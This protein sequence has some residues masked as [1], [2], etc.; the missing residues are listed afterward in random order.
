MFGGIGLE[1]GECDRPGCDLH[2]MSAVHEI[3]S[4]FS[5]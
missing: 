2:H 5:S 1:S 3:P 4:D